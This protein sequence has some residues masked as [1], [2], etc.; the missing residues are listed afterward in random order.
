MDSSRRHD[1]ALRRLCASLLILVATCLTRAPIHAQDR[2]QTIRQYYHTTWTAKDGAPPEIWALD[3]GSDG[4]LWLGTGSG[5]YR[6]DGISFQRHELA[7]GE[8]L[9]S[10]DITALKVLATNEIWIGYS[11]GGVSRL[12]DGRVTTFTEDDGIWP[13]MITKF[14]LGPDGGLWVLSHDG[15]ARFVN[16][17]WQRAGTDWNIPKEVTDGLYVAR[18]GVV[19]LSTTRSLYFSRPGSRRFEPT[20]EIA[21]SATVTQTPDG[22]MWIADSRYGL[23]RMPNYV[24][25][26]H[27]NPAL[28]IAPPGRGL[29]M[30]NFAVDR[31]GVIWGTDRVHGGI[32]RFDPLRDKHPTQRLT[33]SDVDTFRHSDGLTAGRSIPV[34]CDREGNIWVG[35]SAGLNRFRSSEIVSD[36]A[37][38]PATAHGYSIAALPDATYITDGNWIYRARPNESARRI[39]RLSVGANTVLIRTSDDAVWYGND[40]F[41]HRFRANRMSRVAV[42]LPARERAI[43]AIAEDGAG[44]LWVAFERTGVYQLRK[45]VWTGPV[46]LGAL[47]MPVIAAS[48]PSGPVWFGYAGS[49][50]SR[51]DLTG[52]RVYS[53]SDGLAVGNVEGIAVLDG[54][55][56]VGGE[57][58]VARLDHARFHTVGPNLVKPLFGVSGIGQTTNGDMLFNGLMGV[59]RMKQEEVRKA[60]ADPTYSPA[61]A[62]YDRLNG[63][64]GVAQQGW[65]AP[66]VVP[67]ADGRIWFISN[68]SVSSLSAE[69]REQNLVL[70][71]VSILSA[72]VHGAAY[73]TTRALTLP[74]GTTSL[75]IG[76]TAAALR[77]PESVRFRYRL[78]GLE[79]EWI[80]AAARREATYNNLGPGHYRFHVVA[81]NEHGVWNEE[82]ATLA[83]EIPPTFIQSWPFKVLISGVILLVLLV[84]GPAAVYV[85]LRARARDREGRL[86]LRFDATLAE[87][88]RLARELHDTLLQGFTGITLQLQAVH[89][90]LHLAPQHAAET[91]SNVLELADGTLADARRMIWDMRQ[92]ELDE[93]DLVTALTLAAKRAVLDQPIQ[94]HIEVSGEARRLDPD[95][96]TTVLRVCREALINV[97]KHAH[98]TTLNLSMSF[99]ERT[100]ELHVCDDGR[101][102]SAAALAAAAANGHWGVSGMKERTA[103]AGGTLEIRDNAGGGT[104]IHLSLPITDD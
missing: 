4:F 99:R 89:Q 98:A 57:L 20:D 12:K 15:L 53:A 66:T 3:Q 5:L 56:W 40:G 29:S 100:F 10:I 36:P 93:L 37:V 23:R 8:Q 9:P 33:D 87:R 30:A 85:A 77:A 39:Q 65:H 45:G 81:A 71:Q 48:D 62:L 6:F 52:M 24:A 95:I 46:A 70:P 41:M 73:P 18:D 74:A 79:P 14:G 51:H 42:P 31:Q 58:G 27:G 61:Y 49:R 13:G 28:R 63:L 92:P 19:W 32:I 104:Q 69:A 1:A 76:Y 80:D 82:G 2:V 38:P 88:T 35:T 64:P 91:L 55:V 22:V 11:D 43:H 44:A 16:G 26:E 86:R 67:G 75:A 83:V 68:T 78:E 25:G 101:G 102:I 84:G 72:A 60:F 90:S 103:R 17:R 54:V 21:G 97:V 50:V 96:E 94:L 47:P 59:V 7:R 34:L